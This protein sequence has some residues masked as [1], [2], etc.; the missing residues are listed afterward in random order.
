MVYGAVVTSAPRLAPSSLN[1]TPT[2]PTLSVALAETVTVPETEAPATGAVMET[3]GGVA[4]FTTVKALVLVAAPPGV[5]TLSG[6]VVAPVGTIS[7]I[8]VAEATVKGAAPVPLNVTA[9]APVKF[10]PLI[11]TMVPTGPLVGVKLVIVGAFITVTLTAAEVA[12]LPAA[13]RATAVTLWLPFALKVVFQEIEYGAVVTSAPRFTPSSLNCT[14]TTPTLSVASADTVTVPTTE[15][16][17]VGEEMETVG[18]LLSTVTLIAA[19]VAV[20]PAASRATAVKLC[21]PLLAVV[22]FQE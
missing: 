1:C 13:S 10:V 17:G 21:E 20:F 7:R 11:V 9:V 18:G 3:A 5:V 15:A 19:A 2:T 14:P 4:S 6:P 8:V 22:V 16:P 12:V